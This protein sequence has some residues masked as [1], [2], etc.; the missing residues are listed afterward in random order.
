MSICKNFVEMVQKQSH[1]GLGWTKGLGGGVNHYPKL[2]KAEW[3]LIPGTI[4]ATLGTFYMVQYYGTF[5]TLTGTI[6]L[7]PYICIR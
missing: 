3:G 7:K 2:M 5:A 6:L 4:C 1:D